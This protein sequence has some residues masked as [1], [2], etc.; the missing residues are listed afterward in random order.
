MLAPS[1]FSQ[2]SCSCQ[3]LRLLRPNFAGVAA[4]VP[5]EILKFL[6]HA[7]RVESK[8]QMSK[9]YQFIVAERVLLISCFSLLLFSFHIARSIVKFIIA[10]RI[11]VMFDFPFA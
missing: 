2:A 5:T 1:A 11:G 10:I 3:F 4:L 8:I 7:R 9:S 6:S